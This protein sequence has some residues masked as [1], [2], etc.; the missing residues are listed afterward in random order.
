[1][2][3]VYTLIKQRYIPS[4]ALAAHFCRDIKKSLLP[5]KCRQGILYHI[6]LMLGFTYIEGVSA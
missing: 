2:L 3:A 4:E 1:M 5:I 6:V